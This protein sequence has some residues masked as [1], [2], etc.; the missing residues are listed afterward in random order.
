MKTIATLAAVAALALTAGASAFAADPET[1]PTPPAKRACFFASQVNGWSTDR[2]GETAYLNVG[3]NQVYRAELFGTCIGLDDATAIGI[4]SRGG[5]STICDAM[6][7]ELI[8]RS[9]I[10]PQRCLVTKLTKLSPEDIA[11]RKAAKKAPKKPAS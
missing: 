7:V 8:V 6:D 9:P 4:Q 11:A 10:G 3:V 5:G 1:K 2:D